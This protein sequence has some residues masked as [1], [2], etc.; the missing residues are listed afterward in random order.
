MTTTTTTTDTSNDTA[1]ATRTV[2]GATAVLASTP[3]TPT[4]S[5][6]GHRSADRVTGS[7]ALDLCA[8]AA[9]WTDAYLEHGCSWW[10]W[11][12]A[13][14]VAAEAGA[15]VRVPGPTGTLPPDDGLGDDAVFAATPGIAAA[16]ADLARSH[17]AA[18]V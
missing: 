2:V 11:A 14:L 17:G 18:Q 9:G 8:V 5:G 7:A 4:V 3:L 1:T 12:A 6:P 16:L 15:V 13:A 10:D